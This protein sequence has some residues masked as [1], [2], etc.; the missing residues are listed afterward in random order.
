L[1]KLVRRAVLEDRA[2]ERVVR[3]DRANPGDHAREHD[4]RRD[5]PTMRVPPFDG[6]E[7]VVEGYER[8]RASIGAIP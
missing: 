1:E 2:V 5:H 3:D 8:K 4:Q 7:H 6:E